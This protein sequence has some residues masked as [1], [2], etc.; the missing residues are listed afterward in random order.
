MR[1]RSEE[2]IKNQQQNPSTLTLPP[3]HP[4][5]PPWFLRGKQKTPFL[6]EKSYAKII[7]LLSHTIKYFLGKSL[8]FIFRHTHWKSNFFPP[9]FSFAPPHLILSPPHTSPY[10]FFLVLYCSN[11]IYAT[12]GG[13]YFYVVIVFL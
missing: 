12:L 2:L 8:I 1:P 5:S 7:T 4:V 13:I 9:F 3:H 11:V 6:R 10:S